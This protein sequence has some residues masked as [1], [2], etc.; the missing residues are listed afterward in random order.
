[1]FMVTAKLD[2]RK[3]IGGALALVALIAAAI[4][5]FG[6]GGGSE[7][8]AKINATVKSNAQRVKYLESLGWQVET[9]P[10]EEQTVTIP[11]DFSEVYEDYNA[12]QKSQGFDLKKYAGFEAVRYTYE[13]KNHPTATGR[14][15][16]D[17]IVYRNK[18]IAADVQ[19]LS[20][21]NGSME[22]INFPTSSENSTKST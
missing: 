2:R 7:T 13:V 16:A 9:E 6:G 18:V 5:I 8:A 3:V 11:R 22:G 1:M 10:V 21:E 20:A 12:L 14:V 15:V 19:S 17:M 4:F